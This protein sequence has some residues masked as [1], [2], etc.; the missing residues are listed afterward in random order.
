MAASTSIH[1][2]LHI[3]TTAEPSPM[4][5]LTV[6]APA[7]IDFASSGLGVATCRPAAKDL[8]TVLARGHDL[9]ACPANAVLGD[10]DATAA[11]HYSPAQTVAAD[12]AITLYNGP[13]VGDSPGVVAYVRTRHPIRSQLVYVGR[14]FNAPRPFGLGIQLGLPDIPDSP[15]GA[16]IALGHLTFTLGAADTVYHEVVGGRR[17]AYRPDGLALPARCPRSGVLRFRATAS[18][19]SGAARSGGAVVKCPK[20]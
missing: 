17:R 4:T 20:S 2:D 19:A 16:P 14:L 3:D 11:I 15:F 6:L 12:G 8:L 10:G 18:F 7:G 5:G 1:L 9:R 13:P